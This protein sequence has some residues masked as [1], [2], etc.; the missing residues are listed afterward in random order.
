VTSTSPHPAK[1][2]KDLSTATP[3]RSS[4]VIR[5]KKS[6]MVYA[7]LALFMLAAG[8]LA[9]YLLAN[10]GLLPGAAPESKG[11]G[12]VTERPYLGAASAQVVVME[13][14]DFDCAPCKQF[15]DET[16]RS[17]MDEYGNQIRFV[18]Y[19]F[20]TSGGQT[21]AEAAWCAN[22]QGGYWQ[23]HNALFSN[24]LAYSSVDQYASLAGE[25][26][27]DEGTFRECVSSGKYRDT[28]YQDYQLGLSYGVRGTPSFVINGVML[29]GAQPLSEFETVINQKL[30]N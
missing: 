13:F 17:L 12:S 5:L 9:I 3:P 19:N 23:Y 16:F 7:G 15:H 22:E 2:E 1:R 18:Y 26:K 24:P 29:V 21:A 8:G 4:D 28:V 30:K 11:S 6:Q 25:L 10:A 14:S 20:P 27:L